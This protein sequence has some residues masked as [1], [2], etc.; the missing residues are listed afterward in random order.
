MLKVLMILI[1]N[2][3]FFTGLAK[4]LAEVYL[5]TDLKQCAYR[6]IQLPSHDKM[7]PSTCLNDGIRI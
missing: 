6:G 3:H 7:V 2:M 5:D 4:E 1:H